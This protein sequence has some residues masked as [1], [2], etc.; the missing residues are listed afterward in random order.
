[1]MQ[2]LND[3]ELA[4]TDVVQSGLATWGDSGRFDNLA[5]SCE[6]HGLHTGAAL[7]NEISKYIQSRA[8]GL[9]KDD[10]PLASLICRA[11]R[12]IALCRQKA[13]EDDI[14]ARWADEGG[15]L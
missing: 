9:Q 4:L 15:T 14:L 8:H 7:M 13:Q 11:V 10:L 3:M 6:A 1:M 5:E 12:Y 2:L